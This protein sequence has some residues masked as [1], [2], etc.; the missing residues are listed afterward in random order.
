MLINELLED[1][2]LD[3]P[4]PLPKAKF[5]RDMDCTPDTP[6][7]HGINV[8]KIYGNG[9]RIYPY[10]PGRLDTKHFQE[11]YLDSLE[12]LENYDKIIVLFSG[13]KDSLAS[14]L[15]LLELGV[16]EDKIELWHHN[17][18]LA[19]NPELLPGC[20]RLL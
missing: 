15:Y 5:I 1:E 8:K 9:E 14:L 4:I 7:T 2:R 16:P 17:H 10:V 11:I 3:A 12:P 20:R 18:G 13:G 19:R 6:V